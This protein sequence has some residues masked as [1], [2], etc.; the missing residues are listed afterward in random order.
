MSSPETEKPNSISTGAWDQ[1]ISWEFFV[2]TE[3]P[4][5]DLCTAVCCIV[6]FEK[7]IFLVKNKR[8]WE[9]PAGHIEEGETLIDAIQR[10]VVEEAHAKIN[11][12]HF[13]G[14]KKLTAKEQIAKSNLG[15]EFY[16]FPYS[17]IVFYYAEAEGILTLPLADDVDEIRLA[18]FAEAQ[19]LLDIEGK[20]KNVF[21]YLLGNRFIHLEE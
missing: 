11:N 18:T 13:F 21:E 8:G 1:N 3:L 9:L 6:I 14:Y 19:I 16:P 17:Y 5:Q 15:D 10:E 12:P 20:Y 2:T 7:K 4:P